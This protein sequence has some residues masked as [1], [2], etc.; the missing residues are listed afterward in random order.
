MMSKA[1]GSPTRTQH[2]IGRQGK[3]RLHFAHAH[4]RTVLQESYF[5]APLQVMR[6]IRDDSGAVQI[7]MLSPTGGVVQGD[8]YSVDITLD[9][10]THAVVTTIAANKVYKM[11]DGYARQ[12]INIHVG[13][14]AIL[15]F[16]PDALIL[17]KDAELEQEIRI[18]LGDGAVCIFQDSIMG[19]RITRG[20]VLQFRRF[21]NLIDVRDETGLLMY[22][23]MDY[24]P[25]PTDVQR[26]GLFDGFAIWG[27][28]CVFGDLA[29]RGID[30]HAFC[31]D[32]QEAMSES[33][34][35]S[36][37]AL[38]RNGLCAR[39]LSN[40]LETIEAS[41]EMLR[42]SL[43]SALNIRYSKIRK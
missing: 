33:S 9:A 28:W 24:K 41:F 38:H 36:I 19:G 25:Q 23:R 16:I 4:G 39:F 18:T 26:I 20:E 21:Y 3:L 29:G 13:A 7:Y 8:R 10:G 31:Q 2:Q 37:S 15:E 1:L 12:I 11:P 42:Q 5:H 27:T 35:A 22:D 30:S 17:F 43:R 6:P 32:H 34:L 40:R 14:G